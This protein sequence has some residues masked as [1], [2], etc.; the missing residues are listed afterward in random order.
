[1]NLQLPFSDVG[2]IAGILGLFFLLVAAYKSLFRPKRTP[3]EKMIDALL[4]GAQPSDDAS[5]G[6]DADNQPVR[7]QDPFRAGSDDTPAPTSAAAPIR[8]F[9]HFTAVPPPDGGK[10]APGETYVWE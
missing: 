9:R 1:M 10:Q 7:V 4:S 8:A 2:L 3:P 6:G 5:K